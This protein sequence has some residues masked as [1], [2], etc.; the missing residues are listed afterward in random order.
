MATSPAVKTR[1]TT[2]NDITAEVVRRSFGVKDSL[3][4]RFPLHTTRDEESV[5]FGIDPPFCTANYDFV[6][7]RD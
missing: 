1:F 5:E 6:P 4:C 2:E 7:A 3:I